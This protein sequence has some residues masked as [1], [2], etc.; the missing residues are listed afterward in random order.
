MRNYVAV[1]MTYEWH[2]LITQA[3]TLITNLHDSSSLLQIGVSYVPGDQ[4]S[5]QLGWVEPLGRRG[6]EFGGIPV[7]GDEVTTGSASRAYLRW[8]YYF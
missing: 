6:E 3:T 7:F 1:G 5:I 2:P 8:V 4:Q